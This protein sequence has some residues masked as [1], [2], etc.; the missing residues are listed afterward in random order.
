MGSYWDAIELDVS[1]LTLVMIARIEINRK[2]G[3]QIPIVVTLFPDIYHFQ[4]QND[5]FK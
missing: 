5:I 1:V 3:A 2:I 4:R